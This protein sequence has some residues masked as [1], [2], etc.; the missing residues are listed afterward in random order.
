MTLSGQKVTFRLTCRVTLGGAR[1]G[2]RSGFNKDGGR[3][4]FLTVHRLVADS[5]KR[6]TL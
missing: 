1:H 5:S 6:R 3:D 2:L 4:V